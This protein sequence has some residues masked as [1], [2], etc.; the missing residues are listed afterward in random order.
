MYRSRYELP[1]C[2]TA[3]GCLRILNEDGK[4]SPL[5]T[6]SDSGW[7]AETALDMDMVSAGCPNC[8]IVV[9]ETEAGRLDTGEQAATALAVD[10]ISA[11]W[12]SVENGGEPKREPA[13]DHPGI[14]VFAAAGDEAYDTGGM[15][16]EY[17]ATSAYAI[18]VGGTRLDENLIDH[19]FTEVV[20]SAVG[21]FVQH[22]D[23]DAG[24]P[25][26][27]RV[28][29]VRQAR[30]LGRVGGGRSADRRVDL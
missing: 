10:A 24:I 14:G 23:R 19:T 17:P 1:P 21:Q 8:N 6:G 28:G 25:A 27:Q 13:Y 4:P 29:R 18:A 20:W 11:S 30:V 2:T 7:E 5:P 3:S 26:G 16:P 22:V 15:G 12:G 9:I